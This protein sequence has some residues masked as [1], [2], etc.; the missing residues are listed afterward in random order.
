MELGIPIYFLRIKATEE[1]AVWLRDTLEKKYPNADFRLICLDEVE[2][3]DTWTKHRRIFH[4]MIPQGKR[5]WKG[6]DNAGNRQF[7]AILH[8]HGLID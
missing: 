3:K 2:R 5:L 8:K 1:E 6:G 7:K 4:E